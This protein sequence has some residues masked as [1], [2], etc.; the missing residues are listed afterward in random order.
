MQWLVQT[1]L[2]QP[3]EQ[4][5]IYSVSN[6]HMIRLLVRTC[7]ATGWSTGVDPVCIG[8]GDEELNVLLN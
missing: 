1:S 8:E 5:S 3:T 7:N 2:Y 4:S 6:Y